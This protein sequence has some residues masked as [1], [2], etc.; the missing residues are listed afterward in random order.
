MQEAEEDSETSREDNQAGTT[1]WACNRA[2]MRQT[3][4]CTALTAHAHNTFGCIVHEM[5]E[6]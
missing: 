5:G 4:L 1:V 3:E 2:G 6:E